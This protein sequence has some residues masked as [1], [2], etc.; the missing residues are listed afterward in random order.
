MLAG[1][2]CMTKYLDMLSK[3]KTSAGVLKAG[4]GSACLYESEET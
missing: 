1:I 2:E 4:A 3:Y